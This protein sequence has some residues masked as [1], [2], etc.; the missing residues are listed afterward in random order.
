MFPRI[1]KIVLILKIA[2]LQSL[3]QYYFWQVAVMSGHFELGEIIKNHNDADVGKLIFKMCKK[4]ER[5][6][7]TI[8][9]LQNLAYAGCS[10][11]HDFVAYKD[12][13]IWPKPI[14]IC[15]DNHDCI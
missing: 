11:R 2:L 3:L 5:N 10:L 12:A 9:L 4:T 14:M 13:L 1:A 7:H 6:K 8:T 15:T